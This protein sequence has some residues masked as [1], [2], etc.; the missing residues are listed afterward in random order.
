MSLLKRYNHNFTKEIP[1]SLP[2]KCD[3]QHHIDLIPGALL[4]KPSY[5]MNLKTTMQIQRKVEEVIS[6]GLVPESL[7]P[8]TILLLLVLK[9]EESK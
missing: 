7:S 3:I 8:Y 5:Q 4:P 1:S 6:K 2:P 9:K